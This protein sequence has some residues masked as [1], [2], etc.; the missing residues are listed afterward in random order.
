MSKPTIVTLCLT[1]KKQYEES[2]FTVRTYPGPST[3]EKKTSCEQCHRRYGLGC[4][5]Q[6]VVTAKGGKR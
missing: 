2:G 1:C 4:L 5:S 3:T 6:Y